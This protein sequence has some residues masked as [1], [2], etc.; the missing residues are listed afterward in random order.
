MIRKHNTDRNGSSWSEQTK[1]LVWQKGIIVD[2]F[3]PRVVRKDKCGF[4]MKYSEHGNRNSDKGWEIDHIKAV[5]NGG[6]DEMYNLQPLH[7]RNN[8][9]KGD[10]VTWNCG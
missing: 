3:D 5:A 9:A 2:G 6:T 7:W 10:K 4:I 1:L 8:S